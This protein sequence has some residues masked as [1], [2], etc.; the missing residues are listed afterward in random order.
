MIYEAIYYIDFHKL[1]VLLPYFIFPGTVSY[2]DQISTYCY[3]KLLKMSILYGLI[4]SAFKR[5]L[6]HL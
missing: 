5:N 4:A 2:Y 6:C 1:L 3:C